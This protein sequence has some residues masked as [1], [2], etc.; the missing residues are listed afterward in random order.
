MS[1]LGFGNKNGV[2]DGEPKSGGPMEIIWLA[3]SPGMAQIYRQGLEYCFISHDWKQC[4]PFIY[5]KDFLQDAIQAV[6]HGKAVGIYGFSYN[7]ATCEP[8]YMERTRMAIANASDKD[9]ASK[10]PH[11]IDFLNQFEKQLKLV[12]SIARPCSNPPKTYGNGVF[13]LDSSNR[14]MVSPPMMSMYA[15]LLRVGFC[16]TKGEDYAMT[17]KKIVEGKISPYQTHDKSYLTT[18]QVGI[19]KILK[20]GYARIFYKDP[21]KNYPDCNTSSMHNST[22]IVAFSTGDSKHVV[23]HWHRDLE[24][25]E[26]KKQLKI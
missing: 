9:F 11:A 10:I 5:C 19:E 21:K 3:N 26:A 20:F 24:K 12:R 13:I 2:A 4:C 8:L 23:N 15:L 16:H 7:P 1:F 14:W 22:G 17:I 18:A 6:H 25:V